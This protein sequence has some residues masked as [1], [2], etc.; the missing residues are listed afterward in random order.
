MLRP[1]APKNIYVRF[2]EGGKK[3]SVG[4]YS[5]AKW[6]NVVDPFSIENFDAVRDLRTQIEIF[7]RSEKRDVLL[8]NYRGSGA[9]EAFSAAMDK[10]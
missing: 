4:E 9:A 6:R 10:V 1:L 3:V 5:S 7:K 8:V 2:V